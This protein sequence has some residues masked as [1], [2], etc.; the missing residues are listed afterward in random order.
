MKNLILKQPMMYKVLHALIPI[1]IFSILL[2]GWR[3]LAVLLVANLAAFLSEY[4]FVRTKPNGKVSSAVFVTGTL[5]GLIVPPTL[6]LWMV[7]VG[8]VTAIVFGKMVFGGF[9]MN[10][11]NPAIVGRTFIYIAFANEMTAE[12]VHPFK[13]LPGGFA[14][15][16]SPNVVT[17]ATPI[18]N[19]IGY[20]LLDLFRGTI[21]GSI[22]ETSAI[23]IL[24]GAIYL[25]VTKTAKWEIM[26]STLLSMTVFS[27][28]FYPSSE[29]IHLLISGGVL[30]G[31]VFMATDP[32]TA[33]KKSAVIWIYGLLIGFLT[34]FI[35]KYALWTEGFMFALLL[36]NSFIPLIEYGVDL[37]TKKRVK[38]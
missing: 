38:K 25:I 35:R 30:F 3:V 15:W 26:V 1:A 23:L 8:S 6:P 12:W 7:A 34:V 9:A 13:S 36:T 24:L 33:P 22:G 20:P 27:L 37:A 5:L 32:I 21:P 17:T 31:T 11:F 2:F 16:L 28:I 19:S 14:A 29:L 4:V 18:K 10:I